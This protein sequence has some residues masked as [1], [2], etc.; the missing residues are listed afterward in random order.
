VSFI[1]A[2]EL[3][4]DQAERPDEYPFTIPALR[5]LDRLE[6]DPAVTFLAGENG[7]GKST[8]IE[9]IAVAAGLNAE[10]G[11]QNFAFSTRASHSPLHEAMR[12][13]RDGDRPQTSF[14]LRAESFFNVAT[15][16]DQLEKEKKGLL[17]AY[18]GA[19]LHE[20]SHGESFLALVNNRFGA[21]GLYLLD[22]P[23]AALSV[24]GCLALLARMRALVDE[25]SQFVV[26]THSPLLLAYPGATIYALGENGLERVEYEE[27]EQFQLTRSFL[28][29]PERFFRHLFD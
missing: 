23:E 24:R 6:L 17:E 8:M 4:R 25:A 13:V 3:M 16:V 14:F 27:T 18:G 12:V 21:R 10:G 5:D 15:V 19:S 28:E 20:R 1:R 9:A 11:T 26:A 22:E 2:V 29:D 7:S